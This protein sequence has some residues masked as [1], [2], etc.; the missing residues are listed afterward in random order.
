MRAR[1]CT[2]THDAAKPQHRRLRV[3]TRRRPVMQAPSRRIAARAAERRDG[4][5]RPLDVRPS[6]SRV[7][8]LAALPAAR[9]PAVPVRVGHTEGRAVDAPTSRPARDRARPARERDRRARRSPWTIRRRRRNGATGDVVWSP[10]QQRGYM[11]FVGLAT[12][13]PTPVQYQL[14]I[15]DQTR[16]AGVPRRRRRVRRVGDRRGRRPDQPQ[17]PRR[18]P[19]LFAVTIEK[20]GGV[21]V[22]KRERIVVTATRTW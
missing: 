12:N 20:P 8:W 1:S 16:D 5:R 4:R 2:A 10:S 17:A 3:R 9:R 7:A 18:R 15:F 13:D 21:V 6:R 19:H 11:R 22:S 14:W